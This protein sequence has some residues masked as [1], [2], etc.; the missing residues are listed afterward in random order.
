M[1]GEAFAYHRRNLRAIPG[2]FG[3]MVRTR[4]TVGGL[5]GSGDYVQAQRLRNVLKREFARV[6]DEVDVVVTPTSSTPAVR[7]DEAD[8]MTTT[9]SP[10]FTSPFNM[11]GLPAISV[12]C[13]F[14]PQGLPVGLQIAGRPFDEPTVLRAAYTFEQHS[15]LS[16]KRPPL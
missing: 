1:L 11:T 10:S 14:T 2:K 16:T 12:P 6:L 4:F 9:R 5:F 15:G 3:E 7:F 13:G 8:V